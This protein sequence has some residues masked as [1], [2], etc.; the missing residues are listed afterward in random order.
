MNHL[1]TDILLEIFKFDCESFL[2]FSHVCCRWRALIHRCSLF[3]S[4]IG[5]RLFNPELDQ[6]AAYW[7]ERVSSRPLSITIQSKPFRRCAEGNQDDDYLVPLAGILREHMARCEELEINALPE[8]VRRFMEVCAG[9]TPLLRRVIIRLPYDYHKDMNYKCNIRYPCDIP[10]TL[11]TGHPSLPRAY[12]KFEGWSPSFS[13][14]GAALTVLEI[15]GGYTIKRS[16]HLLS[17]LRSCPNLVKFYLSRDARR[18]IGESPPAER[19]ALPY[20]T[21][22]C[23]NNISDVDELIDWLDV[24][25]LRNLTIWEFAWRGAMLGAF[26][27]LFPTC[28]SLSNISLSCVLHRLETELPHFAGETLSLPAVTH[29]TFYGNTAASALLSQLVLPNVQE[30]SLQNVPFDVIHQLVS[31]TTQLREASFEGSMKIVEGLPVI[32]LPTLAS[33]EII[34]AIGCVDFL[35]LPQLASLK[36]GGADHSNPETPLGAPL[37]T[38]VERSAP[39][40]ATLKLERL[41]VPDQSLIWCLERLPLLEDLSLRSCAIT[42]AVLHALSE[43]D[44]AHQARSFIVPRLARF[45]F[46]RTR[47]TPAGAISFLSSRLWDGAAVGARWPPLEG[48]ITFDN[49]KSISRDDRATIRS[50]GDFLSRF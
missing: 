28:P 27:D 34:G 13:S 16:D 26:L 38:L 40:L 37:S 6:Q 15:D 36:F 12:V 30:L 47:I 44:L 1:P 31:S 9:D 29:F 50:M 20:L 23:I 39:P 3:W 43:P 4:R 35:H 10:F 22:L 49:H 45:A 5:L 24:P 48:R 2:R 17:M 32:T 11:T 14:F 7:L 46:H 41:N 33:L 8:Q 25:S 42:D 19:V 21:D 18:E